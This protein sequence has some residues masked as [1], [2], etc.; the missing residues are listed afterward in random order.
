MTI[1]AQASQFYASTVGAGTSQTATNNAAVK[2]GALLVGAFSGSPTA[3]SDNL[4]GAWT[5]AGSTSSLGLYYMLNSAA[6]SIGA[7]TITLTC[8]AGNFTSIAVDEFDSD[9]VGT[10]ALDTNDGPRIAAASANTWPSNSG[11]VATTPQS[12][13]VLWFGTS[14]SNTTSWTSFTAGVDGSGSNA[15]T[16]GVNHPTSPPACTEYL[17]GMDGTHTANPTAT[18]G[19]T[20]TNRLGGYVSFQF[21]AGIAAALT[22]SVVVAGTNTE[23]VALVAALTASAVVA[24]TNT[25]SVALAA[26]LTASAVVAGTNTEA[27]ALAAA[28]TASAIVA[29]TNTESVALAAAPSASVVVA[30]TN[31]ETVA[32]AGAFTASVVVTGTDTEAVALA[33]ALTASAVVAG[34]NT[35]SVALAAA[36]TASVVVAGTAT[37]TGAGAL[38]AALT[39]SAV[40]AGTNTETV[41]LAAAIT[42][43]ATI[44][45]TN[46]EQVALA[47]ATGASMVLTAGNTQTMALGAVLT[48][49]AV[50]AAA[51]GEA[52]ALSAALTAALVV[53]GLATGGPPTMPPSRLSID[54]D[55]GHL[56]YRLGTS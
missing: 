20:T 44:V 18:Y 47:A 39:A 37:A 4:N 8:G 6:A 10:W 30:G 36:L 17:I 55:T 54:L 46:T 32:L 5:S 13:S 50:L 31:T 33:T 14:K 22:A 41:A 42:A 35:E 19:N 3:V 48:A 26:A 1:T 49:L 23:R 38:A 52:V 11:Q 40:V 29:G 24:S 34:T 12:G 53:K 51:N 16:R 45:G 56:V 9:V 28:L 27:V 2:A 7:M 43:S 15:M 25:E 21:T